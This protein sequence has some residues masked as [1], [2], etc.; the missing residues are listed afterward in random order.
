MTERPT[1][2]VDAVSQRM[3]HKLQGTAQQGVCPALPYGGGGLW[4]YEEVEQS[5]RYFDDFS[6]FASG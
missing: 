4:S 5:P 3:R 1:S 2:A 6:H